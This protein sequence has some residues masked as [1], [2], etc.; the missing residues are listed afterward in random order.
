MV[1]FEELV[2]RAPEVNV[3]LINE[4]PIAEYGR[5]IE[6]YQIG[7]GLLWFCSLELRSC[8]AVWISTCLM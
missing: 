5:F 6:K 3:P 1:G 2:W 8:R 4:I 7:R